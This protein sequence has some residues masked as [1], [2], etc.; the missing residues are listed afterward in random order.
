MTFKIGDKVRCKWNDNGTQEYVGKTGKITGITGSYSY[1]Y[2]VDFTTWDF[3]EK[4]LELIKPAEINFILQYELERDPFETFATLKEVEA[5]IKELAKR[6]DL[7][8]ESI[9]VYQIA[10]TYEVSLETRVIFGG[11]KVKLTEKKNKGKRKY[12][13]TRAYL[14]K[15]GLVP[16]L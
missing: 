7:K 3:S 9:K 13:H 1:P 12:E 8:R 6:P 14:E 11:H 4:E 2:E 5:R 16:T 10:K 15:K